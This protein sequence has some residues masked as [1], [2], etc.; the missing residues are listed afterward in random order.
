MYCCFRRG[1]PGADLRINAKAADPAVDLDE[2][3]GGALRRFD[4]AIFDRLEDG[5]VPSRMVLEF[6]EG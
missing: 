4:N 2:T 5:N 6:Q 3:N 1:R